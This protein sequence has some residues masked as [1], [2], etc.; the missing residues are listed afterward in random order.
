MAAGIIILAEDNQK[1]RKLYVDL[2]EADGFTVIT[3][4][5]GEEALKLLH[6]VVNPSLIVLDIMMPKFDGIETC[7]RAQQI[8]RGRVPIVFLSALEDTG[9]LR[10]CLEA[11]GD[12]Y[13][14]KSASLQEIRD[15]VRYWTKAHVAG[16]AKDRRERALAELDRLDAQP[17]DQDGAAQT[18]KSIAEITSFIAESRLTAEDLSALT[19]AE[20]LFQYGVVASVVHD[21]VKPRSQTDPAYLKLLGR[22]LLKLRLAGQTETETLIAHYARVAKQP[23]F[24]DGWA[25]GQ[26][27]RAKGGVAL[28]AARAAI[29]G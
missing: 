5:D 17:F 4:G 29:T 7:R 9:T 6:K 27:A 2:L 8:L 22:V 28:D 21:W 14:I 11:G 23:P 20:R 10:E 25:Q 16:A 12:D 13:I 15:R 3:A 1:L 24:R 19:E 26:E 18:A